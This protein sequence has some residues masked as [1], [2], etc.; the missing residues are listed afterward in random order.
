MSYHKRVWNK[1]L[2][3]PTPHHPLP[4]LSD[5]VIKDFFAALDCPRSLTCWLMFCNNEHDQLASLECDPRQYL[6]TID[7]RSAYAATAFLSKYEHLSCTYDK[8]SV[9]LSKF[10]QAEDKCARTNRRFLDLSRDT[11]FKGETVR[12]HNAV[13]RKIERILGT[14]NVEDFFNSANWGPGASVQFPSRLA[15]SANKFLLEVGIT[16]ELY[17]VLCP[18]G[19]LSILQDFSKRWSD[20]LIAAGFPNFNTGNKVVTVPKNSKT[21]RVIAIEPGMNLW[22]QKAVGT[23][24]RR[25]LGRYGVDLDHQSR[26]Q[27]LARVASVTG[28]LAT[29]DFSAASDTISTEVVRSLLPGDWFRWLDLFRCSRGILNAS[30]IRW[31]KFSSMGN[32]FTFELESLIFYAVACCCAENKGFDAAST[33]SVY[34]DDVILPSVCVESFVQLSEFYGFTIN[35]QK[36]F[37]D[38]F[39]RESCGSYYMNGVDVK[40]IFLKQKIST[41]HSRYKIA[42][43]IRRLAHRWGFTY[44]CDKRFESLFR[45]LVKSVPESLRFL[46]PDNMGDGGFVSNFDE[47]RPSRARYQ[48]EGYLFHHFVERGEN[49]TVDHDGLLLSR[50]WVPSTEIDLGNKVTSRGRIRRHIERNVLV[51]QWYNLGEWL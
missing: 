38:G 39:F 20:C 40:P 22:F 51:R 15:N 12:L 30:P 32:G 3:G 37:S 47:A 45:F 26:N 5:G 21:D 42:N 33:V 25:K 9:A 24:L 8:K 48:V 11:L 31:A 1:S 10:A 49:L 28:N 6:T 27:S 29:I 35:R 44:H 16:P 23:V 50:L 17:S 19:S 43:A 4:D 13:V 36:S 2:K 46:I 41:V 7:A 14:P 18:G 34:G